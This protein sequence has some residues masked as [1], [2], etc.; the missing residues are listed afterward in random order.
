MFDPRSEH[1]VSGHSFF[2]FDLIFENENQ[3]EEFLEK[4]IGVRSLKLY[5]TVAEERVNSVLQ[6]CSPS[7]P[8]K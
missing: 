6:S 1:H 7:L 8:R 4:L 3:E 5:S 2:N